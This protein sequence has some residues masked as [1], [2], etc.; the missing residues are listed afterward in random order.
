MQYIKFYWK[1]FIPH[2]ISMPFL[3]FPLPIIILLDIFGELY[4]HLC[5]PLY[6]IKKVKRSEYIQI[7]DRAKLAYLTPFQKLGCMYCGYAN[8]L[9]L[10]FKEIAGRTETYWCGIMHQ[11]KRG[12]KMPRHHIKQKFAKYGDKK[13][14]LEKYSK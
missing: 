14:F 2:I 8:G 1:R 6:G 9:L 4:H 7:I 3:W 12:F 10:Y 11:K 13:D 5:F